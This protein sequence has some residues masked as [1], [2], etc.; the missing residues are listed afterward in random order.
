MK[1]FISSKR[2]SKVPA[3][4][5]C[6]VGACSIGMMSSKKSGFSAPDDA[7]QIRFLAA[8]IKNAR[9]KSWRAHA[10]V[11]F[12]TETS[13][14]ANKAFAAVFKQATPGTF[15][16][17]DVKTT[18]R[19]W[20]NCNGSKLAVFFQEENAE[21]S[22]ALSAT[23]FEKIVSDGEKA[24]TL[25]LFSNP[26]GDDSSQRLRFFRGVIASADK[27]LDNGIWRFHQDMDPRY[28]AYNYDSSSFVDEILLDPSLKKLYL[29]QQVVEGSNC[30]GVEVQI[31]SDSAETSQE[32]EKA[33]TTG[34]VKFA[35]N[36]F[37]TLWIDLEHDFILRKA[38]TSSGGSREDLQMMK[39]HAPQNIT[40]A[41]IGALSI[42]DI[43]I[44]TQKKLAPRLV[45]SNGVWLPAL[46]EI[47]ASMVL[48]NVIKQPDGSYDV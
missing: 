10:V 33:L 42:D 15:P 41:Q 44:V 2:A 13:A 1:N 14:E 43:R 34:D 12:V 35:S 18:A 22:Q 46:V 29:G 11:T 26:A 19:A 8:G 32:G 5:V 38:I 25:T 39:T 40:P 9:Q 17:T 31:T 37:Y 4:L 23:V 47:E 20:W 30:A 24:K 16:Q 6:L 3:A 27:S 45:E 21:Q 28:L 48:G 36:M 7:E